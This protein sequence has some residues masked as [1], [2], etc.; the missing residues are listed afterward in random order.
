MQFYRWSGAL[1]GGIGTINMEIDNNNM[2]LGISLLSFAAFRSLWHPLFYRSNR[3]GAGRYQAR[4]RSC[5]PEPTACSIFVLHVSIRSSLLYRTARATTT[6]VPTATDPEEA[7]TTL[8]M[9]FFVHSLFLIEPRRIRMKI[10]ISAPDEDTGDATTEI[11]ATVDRISR[12]RSVLRELW[13]DPRCTSLSLPL[14]LLSQKRFVRVF[15]HKS[16]LSESCIWL[17]IRD[18]GENLRSSQGW[19]AHYHS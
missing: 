4:Q 14:L 16:M 6:N 11:P 18:G 1:I 2:T 15:R 3:H 13:I 5:C 12:V 19:E 7:T 9:Y 8:K 10:M 17:P